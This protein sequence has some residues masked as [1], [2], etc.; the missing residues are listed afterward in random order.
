[1]QSTPIFS[2]TVVLTAVIAANRFVT[3]AGAVCGAG[4]KALGVTQYAG[5]IGEAVA[6]NVLGTTK[7][8]AGG[9]VAVGGP[10][11]SDASG[12]AIAQAGAGEILGY[13]MEAA[14]GDGKVFE[15][16]LTP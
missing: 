3:F 4:A 9:A 10:V 6:A 13:A 8:E 7:V 1:M 11:K 5:A 14:S 16:L 2:P 15:I 12:K